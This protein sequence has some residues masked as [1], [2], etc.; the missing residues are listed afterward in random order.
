S[1]TS[2]VLPTTCPRRISCGA[3]GS[4]PHALTAP[5]APAAAT[6]PAAPNRPRLPIAHPHVLSPATSERSS[7]APKNP[8][9]TVVRPPDR[10]DSESGGTLARP[11]QVTWAQGR[12]NHGSPGARAE[13]HG[14]GRGGWPTGTLCATGVPRRHGPRCHPARPG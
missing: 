14:A 10:F 9:H 13:P 8:L 12:W 7:P 11:S 1:G 5:T 2:S 6:V 3:G 4:P